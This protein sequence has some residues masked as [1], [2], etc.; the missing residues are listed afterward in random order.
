MGIRKNQM[1]FYLYVKFPD[2]VRYI[3]PFLSAVIGR[4]HCASSRVWGGTA[5]SRFDSGVLTLPSLK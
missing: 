3:S 4:R 2:R 1:Q 5:N